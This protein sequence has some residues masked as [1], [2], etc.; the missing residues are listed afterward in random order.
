METETPCADHRGCNIKFRANLKKQMLESPEDISKIE[1]KRLEELFASTRWIEKLVK[2]NGLVKHNALVGKLPTV[3]LVAMLMK[4]RRRVWMT[5]G[6][7]LLTLS[8]INISTWT[9]RDCFIWFCLGAPI[10]LSSKDGGLD[11]TARTWNINIEF[12]CGNLSW[13][14]YS[15]SY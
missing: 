6:K 1:R 2:R 5:S 7:L 4:P 14:S 9:R 13:G 10:F 3:R 15:A 8:S 12:L 11:G